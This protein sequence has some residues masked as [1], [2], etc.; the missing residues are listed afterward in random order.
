MRILLNAISELR[1]PLP[2]D[3]NELGEIHGSGIPHEAK[4][5]SAIGMRNL[6]AHLCNICPW[7]RF[8]NFFENAS[9]LAHQLANSKHRHSEQVL[10]FSRA[11]IG[12]FIDMMLIDALLNH[13]C[14][15]NDLLDDKGSRV[16]GDGLIAPHKALPPRYRQHPL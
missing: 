5:E 12:T 15:S 7:I 1:D 8:V 3:I 9:V 4:V 14:I 13:L 11:G 6:A 2:A 16:V 10:V